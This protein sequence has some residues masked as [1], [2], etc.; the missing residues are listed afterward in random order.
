MRKG[1]GTTM[2]TASK[3]GKNFTFQT[4]KARD[5]STEGTG[6]SAGLMSGSPNLGHS[7]TGAGEATGYPEKKNRL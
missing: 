5:N 1:A 3:A 7:L 6:K 4:G 2:E